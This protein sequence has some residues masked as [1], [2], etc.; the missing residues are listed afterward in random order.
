VRVELSN[1]RDIR[2]RVTDDGT[3][4]DLHALSD[5][6]R[7]GFGLVSM[8]ERALALGGQLHVSSAP[9]QGTEV[10]VIL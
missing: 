3:G 1:G 7:R 2:L 8:R 10:E 6:S 4:F 9:G 5:Q